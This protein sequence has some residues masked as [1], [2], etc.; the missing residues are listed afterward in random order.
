MKGRL[1]C[2]VVYT[3]Q[4]DWLMINSWHESLVYKGS[5]TSQRTNVVYA[6]QTDW[7]IS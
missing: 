6:P 1:G 3:P 2:K 4:T 7:L 5:L